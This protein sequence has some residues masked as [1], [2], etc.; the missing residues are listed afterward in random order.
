MDELI[1]D[2]T[3][4]AIRAADWVHLRLLLH[5]SLHWSTAGGTT[6]RGRTKVLARLLDFP[7]VGPPRSH[8]LRDGQV[9]RW[10]EGT[11]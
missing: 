8:E 6:I 1:V 11:R 2:R 10:V 7:P 4:D 5:P 3:L 9:Y